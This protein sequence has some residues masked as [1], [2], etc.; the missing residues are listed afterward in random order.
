MARRL[1]IAI[2]GGGISGL[3]SAHFLLQER[4]DKSLEID[5]SLLERSDRLGGVIRSEKVGS[6]LLEWGPEAF[7]SYKPAARE[8]VQRLGLADNLIGS[9]DERRRTYVVRQ[10]A[11]E[12]L[13]EGMAFLAPV[14][15][16][17][18]WSTASL[19]RVGKLRAS[20]EPLIGRSQGDPSIR[21]FFERRLG[22]EFTDRIA[23]PLVS[24]I[25]GG[26]IGRL[27]T[28]SALPLLFQ[29]EQK[30]GSLWKGFRQSRSRS[31]ANSSPLFLTLR[32]GMEEL[33]DLL[34][35]SLE[36]VEIR[37]N[38]ADLR[39]SSESGGF[40]LRAP[41][42]DDCFDLLVLSTPAAS[43][44]E[45]LGEANPEACRI[46]QEVPY[47]SS[48][49]VYL[50]YKRSEFSHPLDGFGFIAPASEARFIDACTWVS[51]KFEERCPSN[52]VL[53]RC[54]AHDG[55]M[56]RAAVTDEQAASIAHDEVKRLLGVSCAPILER[57]FHHTRVMP[58][59]VVG[60]GRR[61]EG[62]KRAL[63]Q[64]PGLFL[65]GA[66]MGGVGIPDCIHTAQQTVQK[67]AAFAQGASSARSYRIARTLAGN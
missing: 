29:L 12:P 6:C 22:R 23:E 31:S 4:L 25:Y 44:A 62:L 5:V 9:R 37:L 24:A 60:H 57:V 33:V 42:F 40:R 65:T 19:T 28:C 41:G 54:V 56:T 48:K 52:L 34:V 63:Q 20:L 26:D 43:S 27:S 53:L 64:T 18:F 2:V 50:A 45:I 10:E 47:T 39:L 13:P 55:R 8:L 59:L 38:L 32:G 3:A 7:V 51:S 15:L 21:S 36:E 14:R 35:K 61:I 49:I 17:T 58:Q 11:L 16:K 1:K 67:A 46:L 66:F 30:F